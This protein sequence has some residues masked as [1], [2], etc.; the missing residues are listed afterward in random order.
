MKHTKKCSKSHMGSCLGDDIVVKGA[1]FC[2]VNKIG[3]YTAGPGHHRV[4]EKHE[5]HTIPVALD[6]QSIARFFA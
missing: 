5:L 6:K 2:S 4:T 3:H 1:S